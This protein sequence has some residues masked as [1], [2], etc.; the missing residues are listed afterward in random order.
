[1]FFIAEIKIAWLNTRKIAISAKINQIKT[2]RRNEN[3]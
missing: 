2:Y 1:M 3:V